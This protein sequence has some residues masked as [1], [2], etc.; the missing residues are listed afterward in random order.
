MS[1][2]ILCFCQSLLSFESLPPPPPPPFSD[3]FPVHPTSLPLTFRPTPKDCTPHTFRSNSK[4]MSFIDYHAYEE[5]TTLEVDI[6]TGNNNVSGVRSV[7][8]CQRIQPID[9]PCA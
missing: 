6:L 1:F 3:S 5:E 8:R 2:F 4:P 9:H 7:L